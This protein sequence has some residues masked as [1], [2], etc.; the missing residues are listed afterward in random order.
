MRKRTIVLVFTL[1][2][3]APFAWTLIAKR[4]VAEALGDALF[5][6]FGMARFLLLLGQLQKKRANLDFLNF[7]C[8][9]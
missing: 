1:C 5:G 7:E 4:S 2:A 8:T 6:L 3:K 9:K